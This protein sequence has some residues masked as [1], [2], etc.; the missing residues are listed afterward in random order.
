MLSVATLADALRPLLT[1]T[2]DELAKPTGFVRR[3]RLWPGS[4]LRRA[5]LGAAARKRGRPSAGGSGNWRAG[6]RWSPTRRPTGWRRRG[7]GS[8]TGRAGRSSFCSSGSGRWAA[9]GAGRRGRGESGRCATPW[10]GCWGR[11]WRT[12]L[13]WSAAARW[14]AAARPRR[15]GWRGSRR[16]RCARRSPRLS[17][18]GR[19][20]PNSPRGRAGS[21][22]VSGSGRRP[23]S[24]CSTPRSPPNLTPMGRQPP[25]APLTPSTRG[26]PRSSR[27]SPPRLSRR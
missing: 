13:R 22:P 10:R 24:A 26:A 17:C 18:C 11:W 20:R 27:A 25:L 1:A 3:K 23:E 15:Y 2:A 4:A 14:R 9:S 8:C 7:A 12:G 19:S 21:G 5:K 16:G 6:R